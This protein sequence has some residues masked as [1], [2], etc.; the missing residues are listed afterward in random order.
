MS[1][2]RQIIQRRIMREESGDN[3]LDRQSNRGFENKEE[4]DKYERRQSKNIITNFLLRN[5]QL[6]Y[7][8]PISLLGILSGLSFMSRD[9]NE[10]LVKSYV[11]MEIAGSVTSGAIYALAMISLPTFIEVCSTYFNKDVCTI[12][13]IFMTYITCYITYSIY[14]IFRSGLNLGKAKAI[15]QVSNLLKFFSETSQ[16]FLSAV[17]EHLQLIDN[18]TGDRRA[19]LISD[20][21]HDLQLAFNNNATQMI[22]FL[23]YSITFNANDKSVY[24]QFTN[25]LS[26]LVKQDPSNSFY[27]ALLENF[28][29]TKDLLQGE[30]NKNIEE[31]NTALSEK[32]ESFIDYF[33]LIPKK[34]IKLISIPSKK[35]IT[36]DEAIDL[37]DNIN[38]QVSELPDKQIALF[39]KN[40]KEL[41]KYKT[42]ILL[43]NEEYKKITEYKKSVINY[44]ESLSV[45]T[46]EKFQQGGIDLI[47][48]FGFNKETGEFFSKPSEVFKDLPQERQPESFVSLIFN[49]L[50]SP[51]TGMFEILDAER[52]KN[53]FGKLTEQGLNSIDS[54]IDL[55]TN[56]EFVNNTKAWKKF[57]S[58]EK[59]Q[60]LFEEIKYDYSMMMAKGYADY[61]ELIYE[62]GLETQKALS[63]KDAIPGLSY[64]RKYQV[65]EKIGEYTTIPLATNIASTMPSQPNISELS[66]SGFVIIPM[67]VVIFSII[68]M[69][70]KKT[71]ACFKKTKKST[72]KNS[73]LVPR[74]ESGEFY[75]ELSKNI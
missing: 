8:T 50:T 9:L 38:K 67:L 18:S 55:F 57:V 70:F 26:S 32:V 16:N 24:Y 6:I 1:Q 36:P 46:P 31:I 42:E 14:S 27:N 48:N 33:T 17:V 63:L 74:G 43:Y 56:S 34:L 10:A 47:K 23:L 15:T 39:D 54:I 51:I 52:T 75:F 22:G 61:R 7:I 60:L 65:V 11:N 12:V 13:Y 21:I 30:I 37:I 44:V 64:V 2:E 53:T 5:P 25:I 28:K 69:M 73:Q 20:I 59:T 41:N 49:P 58:K 3:Y 66:L 29:S 19:E 62:K 68:L 40:I 45:L 71:N 4:E 72:K 35:S